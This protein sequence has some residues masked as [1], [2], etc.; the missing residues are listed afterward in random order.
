M[1]DGFMLGISDSRRGGEL[2]VLR[3]DKLKTIVV[4]K[5]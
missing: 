5:P 1:C 2:L 3:G 4:K